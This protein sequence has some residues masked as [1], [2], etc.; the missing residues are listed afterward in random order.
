M[1]VHSDFLRYI[2]GMVSWNCIIIFIYSKHNAH[3]TYYTLKV[4]GLFK[5]Y[6]CENVNTCMYI[7]H[8]SHLRWA[9]VGLVNKTF[10]I[11]D[12]WPLPYRP[13]KTEF[14]NMQLSDWLSHSESKVG[15]GKYL[16]GFTRYAILGWF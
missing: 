8:I 1:H 14:T 15:H 6:I 7:F 11:S 4:Y 13:M 3:D 5:C 9:V 2:K 12:L 10:L 16:L